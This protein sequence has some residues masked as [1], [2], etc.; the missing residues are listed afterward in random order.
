LSCFEIEVLA[1]N[2][3]EK[4]GYL[5]NIYQLLMSDGVVDRLEEKAFEEIS[6]DIGAGYFE[7]RSGMEAARED[8]FV[9]KPVGRWSD[10]IKNLEDMLYAAICNG[11][12]DAAEKRLIK[13]FGGNVGI[14]QEQF[15]VIKEETRARY[16]EYKAKTT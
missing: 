4:V 3:E 1:M 8:G 6:K 14:S 7:R 12:V 5:A 9:A 15:D 10:R 2:K 11:V 16:A 13:E